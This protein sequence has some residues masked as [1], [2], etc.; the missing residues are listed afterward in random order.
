MQKFKHNNSQIYDHHPEL[1]PGVPGVL[2]AHPPS[3][4]AL[5]IQV[6]NS[7]LGIS[8]VLKLTEPIGTLTNHL[9]V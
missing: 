4:P 2:D 3:Q 8:Q 1:I 7:I 6:L 5:A 9:H